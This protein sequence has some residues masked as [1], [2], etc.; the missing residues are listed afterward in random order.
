MCPPLNDPENGNVNVSGGQTAECT[1]NN[2]FNLI[3]DPILMCGPDGQWSGNPP[4]CEGKHV[5][6]TG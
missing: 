3:G 5:T 1:C 4:V 6:V 2:G